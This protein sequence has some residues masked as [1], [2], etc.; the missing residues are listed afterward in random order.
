[1][2][3]ENI[4]P[5]YLPKSTKIQPTATAIL[6]IIA[7]YVPE[8]NMPSSAKYA[9]YLMCRYQTTND[10]S[11]YMSYEFNTISIMTRNTG[12][13]TFHITGTCPQ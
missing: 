12:I 5:T 3:N 8:T 4:D 10:L 2:L 9:Y 7:N 13:H 6:Q 11:I 1:M